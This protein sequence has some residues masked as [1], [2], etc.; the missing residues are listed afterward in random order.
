MATV[1]SESSSSDCSYCFGHSWELYSLLSSPLSGVCSARDMGRFR[2]TRSLLPSYSTSASRRPASGMGGPYF[3]SFYAFCHRID[4]TYCERQLA[5][6]TLLA[7]SLPSCSHRD[8]RRRCLLSIRSSSSNPRLC[9]QSAVKLCRSSP[10]AKGSRLRRSRYIHG[11][12]C[13]TS[14]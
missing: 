4:P 6:G 8:P 12:S 9:F 10:L 11:N 7:S 3:S 2:A 1:L 14:M 13:G 5:R